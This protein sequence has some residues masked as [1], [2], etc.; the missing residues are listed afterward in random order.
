MAACRLEGAG[1]V[2]PNYRTPVAAIW[3]VPS[4]RCCSSGA[5][6]SSRSASTP[7]YTIVVSCTVI[8]LF[9]SFA[10]PITLGL[11]A[12]GTSKWDKMGPW[13]L[14]EGVFKRVCVLTILAMILIFVLGV[15]PPNTG[16]L[17]HRR[18]PNPDRY[19]LV[20]F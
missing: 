3:T 6:R 10:I 7:V 17:R 12:W 9:L 16:P 8:F 4:C 13:N 20:R 14:G 5:R 2:S 1:K 19:R 18:L 11:F 15:Q